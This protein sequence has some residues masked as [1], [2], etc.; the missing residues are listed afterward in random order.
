LGNEHVP[1]TSKLVACSIVPSIAMQQSIFTFLV[2]DRAGLGV[3]I[4]TWGSY[5]H[6]NFSIYDG[7]TLMMSGGLIF[8]ILGIYAEIVI[9][10]TYGK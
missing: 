6:D 10:K 1:R 3:N 5:Y 9:P 8:L 4:N 2:I 7:V